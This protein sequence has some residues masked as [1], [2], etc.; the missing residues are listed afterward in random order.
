MGD[1]NVPDQQGE[2]RRFQRNTKKLESENL[3]TGIFPKRFVTNRTDRQ[4]GPK[5]EKRHQNRTK[6]PKPN[7]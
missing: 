2:T 4:L 6:T 7:Y 5:H 1:T 3:E